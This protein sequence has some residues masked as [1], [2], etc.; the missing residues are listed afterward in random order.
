MLLLADSVGF[1][2]THSISKTLSSIPGTYVC[3]GSKNFDSKAQIGTNDQSTEDF[4]DSMI[5]IGK[6]HANAIAIHANFPPSIT[7]SLCM[8][9][10]VE[11]A[12]I[13]RDPKHQINSCYN[14]AAKKL[15]D[16]GNRDI[17]EKI[18]KYSQSTVNFMKPTLANC[19]YS[20]AMVHVC[21][22]NYSAIHA[23]AKTIKMEDILGSESTF[24]SVFG[25]SGEVNLENFY[26]DESQ[27]I[28]HKKVADGYSFGTPDK[29]IIH[30]Q[31]NL[32]MLNTST[33][34]QEIRQKLN[35]S[36]ES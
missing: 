31:L 18:H 3:H 17:I 12:V 32:N 19:L 35:Y 30:T 11:Y 16:E 26:P 10:G 2:G 25:I 22:Y 14:W 1:A 23:G 29:E 33:N 24:K 36:D 27:I 6:T 5:S 13:V 34:Y 28:S 21:G 7:K 8:E 15:F 4:L 20:Y 9:K